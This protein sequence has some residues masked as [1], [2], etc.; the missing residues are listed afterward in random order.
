MFARKVV[1]ALR[2]QGMWTLVCDELN[3]E[4]PAESLKEQTGDSSEQCMVNMPETS[5]EERERI[6]KLVKHIHCTSG[7]GSLTNLLRALQKRG[8][9][10]CFG[11]G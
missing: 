1:E 7:H 11:R 5:P 10:P 9:A 4:S 2:Q 8:V 3:E 6:L